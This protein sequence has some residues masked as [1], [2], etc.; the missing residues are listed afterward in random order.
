[1]PSIL[2]LKHL[3]I[4][5]MGKIHGDVSRKMEKNREFLSFSWR[6]KNIKFAYAIGI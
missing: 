2:I 3:S 4:L 1:M 6:E 5:I